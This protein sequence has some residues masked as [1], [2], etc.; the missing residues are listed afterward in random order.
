MVRGRPVWGGG[1]AAASRENKRGC[2]P[3]EQGWKPV[4]GKVGS[5]RNDRL[6]RPRRLPTKLLY[7]ARV[8]GERHQRSDWHCVVDPLGGSGRQQRAMVLA[9]NCALHGVDNGSK[10]RGLLPTL[11]T[12]PHVSCDAVPRCTTCRTAEAT[13][14]TSTKEMGVCEAAG[15]YI[16]QPQCYVARWHIR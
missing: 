10:G 15:E 9:A 3:L 6:E 8:Q 5:L 13:L 4:D 12:R 1:R 16:R 14:A 2:S 7:T 11:N